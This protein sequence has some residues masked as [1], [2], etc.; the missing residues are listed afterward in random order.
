MSLNELVLNAGGKIIYFSSDPFEKSKF[1]CKDNHEFEAFNNDVISG[2]WCEKCNGL[3]KVL[4]RL[5]LNYEKNYELGG[6]TF[7]Y[8]VNGSRKFL[9][10][11]QKDVASQ[12]K[13]IGI[14]QKNDYKILFILNND[15]EKIWDILKENKDINYLEDEKNENV[16]DCYNEE[17]LGP[18]SVVKR[19]TPPYPSNRNHAYGYIRVSTVMQVNDGFSLEAQEYRIA[20]ECKKNNL[21]LKSFFIDRGIS[22]KSI[23]NRNGLKELRNE[24]KENEWIIIASV[25]RLARNTKEF[26]GLVEEIE[27]KSAHLIVMDLNLDITSPSGKLVLT[28]MASQAQFERELT[29]ERVKSVLDHL[30]KNGLLRFKPQIGWKLNPN[31]GKGEPMHIRDEKEQKIIET[32]RFVR[33]KHMHLGI[34][35]FTQLVNDL[36][37]KPPRKS[38][39]WYHSALK[40]LM[41][42]E[43]IK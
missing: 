16:H 18:S 43:G 12:K 10:S 1:N 11:S 14:A 35:G 25:S 19:A 34:T 5:N 15:Y 17:C 6:I 27:N 32:I 37:I 30:R 26:L 42:R 7:D 33:S 38:K 20:Q 22:G 31:Q 36:Q 28:F 2:Y 21:F 39:K 40:K 4:T 41:E 24:I 23:D 8:V 3:E 13:E 9:F 29:S